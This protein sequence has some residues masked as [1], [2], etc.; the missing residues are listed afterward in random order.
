MRQ[1]QIQQI[2]H[3][4]VQI[5]ALEREAV[6]EGF[7]F[8][9]RLIEEWHS[10]IN[11][12]DAP[13]ECLMAAYQSDNLIGIGGINVDPYAPTETGRLRRLYV[14]A[15]KRGQH[16]GQLLVATLVERASQQFNVLRLSTDTPEGD[17]FYLRCGFQ[18]SN[19]D[20]AT[21]VMHLG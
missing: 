9:T 5:A 16:V 10:G 13:G 3:L 17:A 1:I 18:R 12:F 11:R 7:R 14:A 19:E 8:L 15:S 2:L 20:R 21:H 6:A 4:P